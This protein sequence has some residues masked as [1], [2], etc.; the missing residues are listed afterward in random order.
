MVLF[1]FLLSFRFKGGAFWL[2]LRSFFFT[3]ISWLNW[4]WVM[5]HTINKCKSKSYHHQLPG[6]SLGSGSGPE[7]GKGHQHKETWP[8]SSLLSM[9]PITRT[10][11]IL[12]FSLPGLH[13]QIYYLLLF[14]L[15]TTSNFK[16]DTVIIMK[17]S[18]VLLCASPN[19]TF[20][21][22]S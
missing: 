14:F 17:A 10:V 15:I 2:S 1:S 21:I 19:N 9:A 6:S 18:I 20:P 11:F 8:P 12:K 16:E 5:A 4:C 3:I 7:V 22:P 13:E